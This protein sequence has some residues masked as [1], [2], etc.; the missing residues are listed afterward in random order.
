MMETNSESNINNNSRS[1]TPLPKITM[2]QQIFLLQQELNKACNLL[3]EMA[4]RQMDN[5]IF[6]RADSANWLVES[7][8]RP[9]FWM[10]KDPRARDSDW[11]GDRSRLPTESELVWVRWCE[12]GGD[13]A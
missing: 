4:K 12:G 10:S 5:D 6:E 13:C 7:I 9:A 1:K 11:S 3:A 2:E 8:E